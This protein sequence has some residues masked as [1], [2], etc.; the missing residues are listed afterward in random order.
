MKKKILHVTAALMLLAVL[1]LAFGFT[2]KK[3][4]D[5]V[6]HKINIII[7]DSIRHQFLN[8]EK[9]ENIIRSTDQKVLGY[10][11]SVVNTHELEEYFKG[12]AYIKSFEAYKTMDGVLHA[13]VYQREP[14]VRIMNSKGQSYY[15]DRDGNIIPLK[16]DY[17][18]HVIIAN[19]HISESFD[20]LRGGNIY[21]LSRE[22]PNKS[23]TLFSLVKMADYIA[24]NDFWNAQIE[25]I[26]VHR[27][28]ELDIITRVGAHLIRFGTAVDFDKK[29]QKLK[30]LYVNGF[31][32]GSWN[33][34]EIINLKYKN[35][36]IC[37]KR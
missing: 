37:T 33:D 15:L 24:S 31:S 28:G 10:P 30:S 26:Y 4:E 8:E 25:Q 19:G 14:V 16:K 22:N 2:S 29:L 9:I 6:C 21:Q 7:K 18:A 1:G 35:Q 23:K 36:I 27:N 12:H 11:V 13:E 34:Y 32:N 20:P 3:V 17:T 5:V